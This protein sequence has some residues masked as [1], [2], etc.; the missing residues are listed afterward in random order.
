M[1]T[2]WVPDPCRGGDSRM[3]KHGL[4]EERVPGHSRKR[5]SGI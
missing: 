4:R 1:A 5:R 3:E 2:V